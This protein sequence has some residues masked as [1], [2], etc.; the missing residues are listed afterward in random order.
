M[1]SE[2]CRGD[3]RRNLLYNLKSA[4]LRIVGLK[5]SNKEAMHLYL[6]SLPLDNLNVKY[7]LSKVHCYWFCLRGE[8]NVQ[9]L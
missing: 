1:Q 7:V 2:H 6:L 4:Y 8:V 9:G 5:T 3:C